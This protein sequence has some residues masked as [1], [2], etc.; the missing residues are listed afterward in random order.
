[1][2]TNTYPVSKH[3]WSW[4]WRTRNIET[5]QQHHLN[6]FC[7]EL[8]FHKI[9]Y[10]NIQCSQSKM[11]ISLWLTSRV[12]G[13]NFA[14][15]RCGEHFKRLLFSQVVESRT[16]ELLSARLNILCSIFDYA[17]RSNE[18]GWKYV[19]I[20]FM[21]SCQYLMQLKLFYASGQ[22]CNPLMI[23]SELPHL[24]Q[25]LQE[26]CACFIGNKSSVVVRRQ[27]NTSLDKCM[28]VYI[29]V[30]TCVWERDRG[31]EERE[32]Y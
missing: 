6:P 11:T 1:M 24:K 8:L 21:A 25:Q 22:P 17:G 32:G 10:K 3:G 5:A 31:R 19:R 29:C 18:A 7:E 16:D 4:T 13:P 14:R 28:G 9:I 30:C 23:D 12:V 20:F 2:E 26:K 15:F 27:N